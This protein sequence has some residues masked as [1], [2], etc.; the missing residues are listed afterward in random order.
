M[1]LGTLLAKLETAAYSEVLLGEIGDLV[2]LTRIEAAGRHHGE[3]PGDYASASVARFSQ[4]A[5][6]EDWLA[7]MTAL[8]RSQEPAATCLRHMAEWA[9]ARDE[10][11]LASPEAPHSPKSCSCGGT[12]GCHDGS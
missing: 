8:E 9:L 5:S 2:L 6:D 4:G 12:G 1:L 7:V 10:Q 3:T 11:E